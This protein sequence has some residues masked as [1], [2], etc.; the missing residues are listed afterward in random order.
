MAKSLSTLFK[1]KLFWLCRFTLELLGFME[2]LQ[3]TSLEMCFG[4]IFTLL[5]S[6]CNKMIVV[7]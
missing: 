2:L 1:K 5:S 6:Y 4:Q 7:V 3:V